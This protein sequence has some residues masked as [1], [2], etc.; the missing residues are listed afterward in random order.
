MATNV[1]FTGNQGFIYL[2]PFIYLLIHF[3]TTLRKKS[4]HYHVS[5]KFI[6]SDAKTRKTG[7][8]SDWSEWFV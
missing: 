5:L 3:E 7:R 1:V 4:L 2:I 6:I 8:V